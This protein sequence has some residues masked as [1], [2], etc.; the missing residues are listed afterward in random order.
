M[1]HHLHSMVS[2]A[3]NNCAQAQR[4]LRIMADDREFWIK[5]NMEL[6]DRLARSTHIVYRTKTNVWITAALLVSVSANIAVLLVYLGV[7]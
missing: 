3:Q 7:F 2:Q 4:T 5:K 6:G 1:E